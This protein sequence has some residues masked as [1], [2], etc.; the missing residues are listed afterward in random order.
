MNLV[1]VANLLMVVVF[2]SSDPDTGVINEGA[3]V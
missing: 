1:F 2:V 3:I